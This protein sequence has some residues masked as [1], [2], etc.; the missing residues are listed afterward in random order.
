PDVLRIIGHVHSDMRTVLVKD[1][2]ANR[3]AGRET[4]GSTAYPRPTASGDAVPDRNLR[5][6]KLVTNINRLEV[7]APNFPAA[8]STIVKRNIG[9]ERASSYSPP[10]QDWVAAAYITRSRRAIERKT[11]RYLTELVIKNDGTA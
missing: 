7:N 6:G 3:L 8:E 1:A 9:A 11:A 2:I 4:Y 10:P 5:E